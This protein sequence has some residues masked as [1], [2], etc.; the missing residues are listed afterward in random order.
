MTALWHHLS[1]TKGPTTVIGG[2]IKKSVCHRLVSSFNCCL[3]I[4][5]E[6]SCYVSYISLHTFL[7]SHHVQCTVWL[8]AGSDGC[9]KQL[10]SVITGVQTLILVFGL[11]GLIEF[12]VS[13]CDNTFISL[14][15]HCALWGTQNC[16][17]LWISSSC[18]ISFQDIGKRMITH[19]LSLTFTGLE[20]GLLFNVTLEHRCPHSYTAYKYPVQG[21]CTGCHKNKLNLHDRNNSRGVSLCG[22]TTYLPRKLTLFF[23][24]P[25]T[26]TKII[27]VFVLFFQSTTLSCFILVVTGRC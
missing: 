15:L 3:T 2:I 20:S 8:G 22:S 24:F 27:R 5:L 17:I 14:C 16:C 25:V 4:K 10:I 1:D 13:Q 9:T 26:E 21:R 19:T 11:V 7:P 6:L 23:F 18:K 12:N